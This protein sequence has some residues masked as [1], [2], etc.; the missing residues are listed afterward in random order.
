M[1][2]SCDGTISADDMAEAVGRLGH[3]LRGPLAVATAA[4]DLL[5]QGFQRRGTAPTP[6]EQRALDR[7]R[8]GL[9]G[10]VEVLDAWMAEMDDGAP[11]IQPTTRNERLR[12]VPSTRASAA[13][14]ASTSEAPKISAMSSRATR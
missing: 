7:L 12:S 6:L 9:V 3:G 10:V 2:K 8:R 11:E 14:S 4:A 5:E 1:K 13:S